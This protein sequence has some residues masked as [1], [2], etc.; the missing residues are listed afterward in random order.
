M[1]ISAYASAKKSFYQFTKIFLES[2]VQRRWD[3]LF[4]ENTKKWEKIEPWLLWEDN[5][6]KPG[7]SSQWTS[8]LEDLVN[9]ILTKKV[10]R[11]ILIGVGHNKPGIKEIT[12]DQ[13]YREIKNFLECI[14]IFDNAHICIA[15]NHDGEY[16]LFENKQKLSKNIPRKR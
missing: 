12:V 4:T 15:N 6:C 8:S 5:V 10:E 2:P 1:E 14:V 7:L 13:F 11:C 16:I 9:Y 3:E